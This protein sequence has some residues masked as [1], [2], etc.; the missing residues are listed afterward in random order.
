MDW[1]S[2]LWLNEGFARFMEFRAIDHIFPDW[3]I[4]PVVA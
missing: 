4:W 2:S 1:W 3:Q